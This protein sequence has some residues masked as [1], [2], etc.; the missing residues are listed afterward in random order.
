M[1]YDGSTYPNVVSPE[2]IV[3]IIESNAKKLPVTIMDYIKGIL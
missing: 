1:P 3:Y 2:G